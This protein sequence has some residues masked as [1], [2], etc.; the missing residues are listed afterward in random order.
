MSLR[1]TS[2]LRRN[3]K[4]QSCEPCRKSKLKCDHTLPK[5][6]RCIQRKID[7]R[8]VYHPAPMSQQCSR[9]TGTTAPENSHAPMIQTVSSIGSDPI[10][11][12]GPELHTHLPTPDAEKAA[13]DGPL[14][15]LGPT[16]Y[17][18][19]FRENAV[20]SAQEDFSNKA[21]GHF[22]QDFNIAKPT[23]SERHVCN[24]ESQ[25][26]IDQG[27]RILR[28]LPDRNLCEKFINRYLS[29]CDVMMPEQPLRYCHETIWSTFGRQLAEPR[30][31]EQLSEMSREL[32]KNAM[33]PLSPS[34]NTQEWMES[35]SGHRLRWEIIGNLFSLFGISAMTMSEWDPLFTIIEDN[36]AYNNPDNKRL[37]GE[38]MR[39]CAEACLALCNDVDC[40]NDLVICLMS[41]VFMLQSLY[42]GDASKSNETTRTSYVEYL[43][44]CQNC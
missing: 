37:Y 23:A 13:G 12:I 27:V 9:P 26:H 24:L 30:K 28:R 2:L 39:M 34:S 4:P 32:C 22:H 17:S 31:D 41:E 7:F 8:C 1:G 18:A 36:T 16:S 3:G 21:V 35:F 33:M 40:V 38:N 42:E 20:Y 25:P 44:T 6:G 19:I 14:G 11:W 15:Y 29:V 43:H 10:D 5:C